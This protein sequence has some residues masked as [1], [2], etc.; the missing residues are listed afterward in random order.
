M[1]TDVTIIVASTA[2]GALVGTV[3]CFQAVSAGGIRTTSPIRYI[4]RGVAI[5]LVIG[6]LASELRMLF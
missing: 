2:L 4:F 6:L 1:N 3:R 5:G